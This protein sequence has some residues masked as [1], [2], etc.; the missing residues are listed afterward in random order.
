M[1]SIA[2]K[3]DKSYGSIHEVVIDN[4]RVVAVLFNDTGTMISAVNGNEKRLISLSHEAAYATFMALGNA[5]E[6]HRLNKDSH[7]LKL[8]NTYRKYSI[9]F[10]DVIKKLMNNISKFK[11]K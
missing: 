5:F 8:S 1:I 9:P 10:S 6:V 4:D 11:A 3:I 7:K 2:N